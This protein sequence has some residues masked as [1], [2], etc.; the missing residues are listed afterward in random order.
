MDVPHALPRQIEQALVRGWAVLTA[1]Q[2]AART[3]RHGFDLRQRT[4]G[5]AHWQPPA[6]FAW[7]TWTKGLWHRLLLEGHASALL[8]NRSQEHSLW[9]A[10]VEARGESDPD[11]ERHS[12][13]LRPVDSLAADAWLLL[14]AY[15]ARRLLHAS[16]DSADTRTFERWAGE[17][18]RRCARSNLLTA[19]QLSETLRAAIS[20]GTLKLA[21]PGNGTES[22]GFLLVGFDVKT[23]AQTALFEAVEAAGSEIDE[24]RLPSPGLPSSPVSSVRVG[25][26]PPGPDDLPDTAR[27]SLVHAADEHLE[28]IACAHWLRAWLT[29]RPGSRLAVI[30]PALEAE[31]AEIDRV[32]RQVLAPELEDIAAPAHSGP[33]EFSLGVPLAQT[34]MFVSAFDILRWATAPLPLDRVSALLLS[35]HFAPSHLETSHAEAAPEHLARAE[36]DAFVVRRQHL[37]QPELSLDDLLALASRP[38]SSPGLPVLLKHLRALR[39]LFR[40]R[41]MTTGERAHADWAAT[42]HEL[43]EAAGWATSG[44]DDSVEFQTRR[45]WESALDELATL[46]FDGLRVGFSTAL[47]ALERIAAETLFAPES[48]HAPIQVMGPLESAGSIFDALWFLRANDLAW[49]A[50]PSPNPL[51]SWRLQR[52]LGM[53]GADPARDS[54]HARRITQRIAASAPTVLFSYAQESAE[55]RQRASLTLA[56]LALEAHAAGNFAPSEPA[57]TTIAIEAV[58]DDEPVPPPPDRVLRGGAG[59]LQS[60]AACSFRA[61]AEKRLFSAALDD[62]GLGLD[63]RERGN[64]VH[65]VLEGFWAEV[66]T[67]AALARMTSAER[68]G[69][70]VRS[71]DRALTRHTASAALGWGRA[72]LAAER[73]R[74]LKLL[75]PWLDYELTRPAFAVKS[76]EE[77]LNDVPIGPLRLNIRVDRVDQLLSGDETDGG[78]IILDYKTGPARPADWLGDRPDAP[79]LPLYAVVSRW[80]ASQSP[81]SELRPLAAIAFASVRP[82]KTMG[83]D[84]YA[85]HEGVLPKP[86]KLKTASLEAQVDEWRGVLTS[87]ATDFHSGQALVSPKQY[88]TTCRYCQQRLLCRLDLAALE[89]DAREDLD[90]DADPEAD[91]G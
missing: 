55:G 12:A 71:I 61:F 16:A 14:H 73:Q 5:V 21:S 4:L 78:E 42:I 44:R 80:P 11:A 1:N 52:E 75:R 76:R 19:A 30:V 20:S 88:P 47:A 35:P 74:L 31:R 68:D 70:L 54:A 58:A 51:L 8:L 72:Y 85:A 63:P 39:P 48:R 90:P 41:D 66:E 26:T 46:D 69:L 17:F 7:E 53:P 22:A 18:D 64:L 3:W 83:L 28:L 9:R 59:I 79:Q 82:G 89:A 13:S 81:A 33:F 50:T 37:L 60:Q 29:E 2:R 77:A 62:R 10:V 34:S 24:F 43:L 23:P 84:G 67:Q 6:I 86:S 56:G 40:N 49:P 38:N 65:V 32:F 87:L 57:P 91:L 45:K 25:R 15:R 36:F 27:G